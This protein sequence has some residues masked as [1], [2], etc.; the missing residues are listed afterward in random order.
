MSV[1]ISATITWAVC[2]PTPGMPRSRFSGSAKGAIASPIRVSNRAIRP[3]KAPI[4]SNS[5]FKRKRWWSVMRPCKA[6]FSSG[7]LPRN[8]FLASSASV[9]GSSQPATIA[10]SMARPETP[11]T[12]LATLASLMLASSSTL[13]MRL[14]TAARSRISSVRC[15]VKSRSARIGGGGMK[16]GESRPY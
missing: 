3:S 1:P 10:P 9:S 13:W 7:I 5:A 14:T 11:S 2:A 8:C 4:W 12:S 16:L 6:R 15:R